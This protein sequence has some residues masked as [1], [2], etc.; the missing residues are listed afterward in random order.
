MRSRFCTSS[1]GGAWRS[2]GSRSSMRRTCSARRG[3]HWSNWRRRTTCSRSRSCSTSPESVC[4]E[5]NSSRPD[6]DFGAHVVRR[7]RTQLRRS[8]KHLKREGFRNVWV[9][10]SLEE[11]AAVEVTR[12]RFGLTVAPSTG[13]STSSGTSTA[14]T[15]S[16]SLCLRNSATPSTPDGVNVTPPEGRRAVFVGDYGDRGP[17]TPAVLRLVMG[18]A[19]AGTAICLPGNHDVKLARKLKGRRRQGRSRA[20]GDPRAARDGER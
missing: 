13:R 15:P 17:D 4:L 10:D 5:R 9:L 7:Q 3:S 2:P 18:M 6:R 12:A 19:A 14:A 11:V 8:I 16:W 1:L 20:R